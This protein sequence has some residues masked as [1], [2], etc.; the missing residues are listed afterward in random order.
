MKAMNDDSVKLIKE[1][2]LTLQNLEMVLRGELE[3]R[4]RRRG[5]LGCLWPD[6]HALESYEQFKQQGWAFYE[7][8]RQS[9]WPEY[10]RLQAAWET[11]CRLARIP[12]A[13]VT[14]EHYRGHLKSVTI[15][16]VP[17]RGW[18]LP[19]E[20]LRQLEQVVVPAVAEGR[21]CEI[22]PQSVF[23]FLPDAAVACELVVPVL[24][25]VLEFMQRE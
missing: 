17:P 2:E 13:E 5:R 24:D 10:A 16:V 22:I 8:V 23:A 7:I 15:A 25:L 12:R 11:Y 20:A 4:G 19:P 3:I 21:P 18:R 1:H 9:H 14:S 6:F